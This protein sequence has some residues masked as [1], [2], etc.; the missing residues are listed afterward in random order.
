MPPA[1]VTPSDGIVLGGATAQTGRADKWAES[2]S[3][4]LNR[5]FPMNSRTLV[6][7]VMDGLTAGGLSGCGGGG[8]TP[9][10]LLESVAVSPA[11]TT[12]MAGQSAQFKA[13]GTYSDGH[14]MDLTASA[15]W[16][17]DQSVCAS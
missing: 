10:G 6:L 15:S 17:V 1:F 12:M 16:T 11:A 8:A 13:V 5:R 14:T 7:I 9:A 2:K 3:G 4:L